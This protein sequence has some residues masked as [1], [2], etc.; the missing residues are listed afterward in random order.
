MGNSSPA[1]RAGH[2][3][4]IYGDNM[5][6]FGGK[7]EDNDKLDDLW[8][9]NFTNYNWTKVNVMGPP[10]ARSGHTACLYG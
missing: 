3:S 2:S 5:V 4:I 10:I 1:A 6:V 9:F 8:Y 7:D